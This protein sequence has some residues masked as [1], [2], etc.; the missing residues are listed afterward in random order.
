MPKSTKRS[1]NPRGYH[2]KKNI[3][4]QFRNPPLIRGG[5]VLDQGVNFFVRSLEMMGM[6]THFSCEG[7]PDGFYI[8]FSARYSKALRIREAGF[9]AIEIERQNYWSMRINSHDGKRSHVDCLR[10][11]AE[12]WA[13]RFGIPKV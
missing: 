5:E 8:T 10:W 6:R 4:D 2:T 9:F 11:A 12:S 13:K 7:H 1:E 3:W